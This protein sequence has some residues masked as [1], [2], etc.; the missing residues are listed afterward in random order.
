MGVEQ[1]RIKQQRSVTVKL[2]IR[3]DDAASEVQ[4]EGARGQ[5][6]T[7]S[8]RAGGEENITEKAQ[9]EMGIEE[10]VV[11]PWVDMGGPREGGTKKRPGSEEFYPERMWGTATSPT[12]F[13]GRRSDPTGQLI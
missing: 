8:G 5:S 6:H 2:R 1:R 7:S 9:R 10:W 11:F 12:G 3:S 13:M 4:T